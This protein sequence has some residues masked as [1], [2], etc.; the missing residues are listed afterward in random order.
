MTYYLAKVIVT[1]ALVVLVSEISKRSVLGGAILASIPLVSVL[2]IFWM[3]FDSRDVS[4]IT[5][6]SMDVFWL[7]LPSLAFFLALPALLKKGVNFYASMG[8]SIALTIAG[9]FLVIALLARF[10]GKH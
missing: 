1:S 6:F 3:Y 7:V 8:L 10:S 2:A 4:R 5:A 9:Y